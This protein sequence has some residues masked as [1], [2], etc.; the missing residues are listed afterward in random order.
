MEEDSV[1]IISNLEENFIGEASDSNSSST[2]LHPTSKRAR[3]GNNEFSTK[4]KGVTA[5]HK[6]KWGAQIYFN[7]QRIWLGTFKSEKE[8]AMAYDSAGIKLRRGDTYRNFPLTNITIEEPKFQDRHSIQSLLDMIRDGSYQVKFAEYLRACSHG[9]ETDMMLQN[10][11]LLYNLLF[12]KE[13]TPSDVGTLNRLVIP[14]KYATEHFPRISESAEEDAQ[15]GEVSDGYLT[16]YD[17]MMR[18]WRFRYCYWKSSQS[19][20]FTKG[21]TRFVKEN[22]LKAHDTISFYMCE[23]K[24]GAK[25]VKKFC[26][27]VHNRVEDSGDLVYANNEHAGLPLE[28]KLELSHNEGKKKLEDV[29]MKETD[30]TNNVEEKDHQEGLK[31][32][33]SHN[34]GANKLEEVYLKESEPTNNMEKK[35]FRLFGV[36]IS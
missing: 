3:C 23:N 15:P 29:E 12:S 28:L 18:S 36:Q 31:L 19:F 25:E 26:M 24:E 9:R 35:G 13:L 32:E 27:I 20:V 6:G 30:A 1:S 33:L 11:R 2:C 17:R 21:W 4:F 5:Q 8:A 22:Q 16:F 7:H 10:E 34:N 14:K